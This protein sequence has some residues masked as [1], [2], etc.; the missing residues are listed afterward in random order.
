MPYW[1]RRWVLFQRNAELKPLYNFD[2][3]Q[4]ITVFEKGVGH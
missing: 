3:V 4:S 2:E 1:I